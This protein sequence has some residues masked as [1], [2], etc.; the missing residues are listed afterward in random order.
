MI[1]RLGQ[2]DSVDRMITLQ[3]SHKAASTEWSQRSFKSPLYGTHQLAINKKL[4]EFQN[5]MSRHRQ[6]RWHRRHRRLLPPQLLPQR[7]D[8]LSERRVRVL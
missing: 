5:R 7:R 3:C 6:T 1:L 2:Y 8:R 4:F